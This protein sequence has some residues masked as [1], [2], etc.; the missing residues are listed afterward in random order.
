[1]VQ[2]IDEDI[3]RQFILNKTAKE[4]NGKDIPFINS[5]ETIGKPHAPSKK[6]LKL[7]LTQYSKST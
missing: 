6:N 1:M 2:K 3:C 5:A 4:F 7:Y